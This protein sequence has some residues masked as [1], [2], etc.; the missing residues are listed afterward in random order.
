M[1]DGMIEVDEDGAKLVFITEP[2]G[3]DF[4]VRLLNE[5]FA[6]ARPMG[7]GQLAAFDHRKDDLETTLVYEVRKASFGLDGRTLPFG[8]IAFDYVHGHR[9]AVKMYPQ[10]FPYGAGR[11]VA[12]DHPGLPV[13]IAPDFDRMYGEG[14]LVNAVR[15]ALI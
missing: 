11:E 7:I 10:G 1:G 3:E 2:V 12:H 8:M 15:L 6:L 9:I 14:A 5:L 4:P 13:V